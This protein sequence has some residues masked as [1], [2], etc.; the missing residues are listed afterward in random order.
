MSKN[1]KLVIVLLIV[2]VVIA[3]APLVALQNAEFGGSDDA[4]SQMISEIQGKRI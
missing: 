2:A 1:K 4:G 3:I